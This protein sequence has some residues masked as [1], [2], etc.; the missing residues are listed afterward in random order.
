MI[1]KDALLP[2]LRAAAGL[3]AP[4]IS[5]FE[6]ITLHETNTSPDGAV[7]TRFRYG[8]SQDGHSQYDKTLDFGGQA[9]FHPDSGWKV[10]FMCIRDIG[11]AAVYARPPSLRRCTADEMN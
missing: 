8:F 9:S 6:D 11:D 1:D 4:Q 10:D 3:S 2:V 5:Q 7:V